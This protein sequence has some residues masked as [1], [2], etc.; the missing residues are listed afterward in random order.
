MQ[1]HLTVRITFNVTREEF[2]WQRDAM[3]TK[4]GIYTVADVVIY[5]KPIVLPCPAIG[6]KISRH[7]CQTLCTIPATTRP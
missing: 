5:K 6:L 2:W 1:T 7:R 3:K 4:A